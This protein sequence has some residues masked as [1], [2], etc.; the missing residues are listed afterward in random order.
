MPLPDKEGEVIP[1]FI[2]HADWPSREFR[3]F[4]VK[5]LSNS[6]RFDVD[7]R[8]GMSQKSHPRFIA[9]MKWDWRSRIKR[10]EGTIHG[11]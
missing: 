8:R 9:Q 11:R 10:V 3:T 1:S 4:R 2:D 6:C 5:Q 7:F